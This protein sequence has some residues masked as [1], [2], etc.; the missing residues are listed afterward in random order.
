VAEMRRVT[1]RFGESLWSLIEDESNRD[2]VSAAQWVRD[3]A[4]ARALWERDRRGVHLGQDALAAVRDEHRREDERRAGAWRAI[5]R[6]ARP[7][8]DVLLEQLPDE[9]RA[10][11]RELQQTYRR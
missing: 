11:F 7:E 2:G 8:L 6:L 9:H 5:D 4:L 1:V 3:A 10:Y